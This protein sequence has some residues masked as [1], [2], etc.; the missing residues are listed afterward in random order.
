MP[1]FAFDIEKGEKNDAHTPPHTHTHPYLFSP[2]IVD[3]E[4][5]HPYKQ[6]FTI[7]TWTVL[8]LNRGLS[9]TPTIENP[10]PYVKIH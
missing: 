4:V 1:W 10:T 5:Y 2:T 6:I 9:I 3:P 7:Q 8:T